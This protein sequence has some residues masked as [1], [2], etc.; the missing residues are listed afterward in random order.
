MTDKTVGKLTVELS[1]ENCEEA[2]VKALEINKSKLIEWR[3]IMTAHGHNHRAKEIQEYI[4]F[5]GDD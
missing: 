2:L 5:L 3:E 4:N 1:V